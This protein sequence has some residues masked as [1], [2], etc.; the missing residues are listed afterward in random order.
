MH[1]FLEPEPTF[2]GDQTGATFGSTNG[3]KD[4]A[5]RELRLC[6]EELNTRFMTPNGREQGPAHELLDAETVVVA[7][8]QFLNPIQSDEILDLMALP[9]RDL[10]TSL[11]A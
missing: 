8:E 6:I 3:M 5:L 2:G 9:A 1:D 10:W 4:V 11:G 7:F